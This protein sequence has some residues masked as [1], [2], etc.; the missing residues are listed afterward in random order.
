MEVLNKNMADNLHIFIDSS[1]NQQTKIAVGSYLITENLIDILHHDFLCLE[2]DDSTSAELELAHR[3][4]IMLAVSTN[5]LGTKHIFIY[6]DCSNLFGLF[7]KKKFNPLHKNA[8]LYENIIRY[9][10]DFDIKI[11]KMKGHVKKIDQITKEQK[12]FSI[13]DKKSRKITRCFSKFIES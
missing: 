12:L 8:T 5:Y 9:F 3:M 4:F 7:L 13:V 11:I 10:N 6:T 1:V 2:S